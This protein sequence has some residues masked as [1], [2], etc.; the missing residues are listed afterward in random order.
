MAATFCCCNCP[1]GPAAAS[2]TTT[3]TAFLLGENISATLLPVHSTLSL[4]IHPPLPL[5]AAAAASQ[6]NKCDQKKGEEPT[7][8]LWKVRLLKEKKWF[9]SNVFSLLEIVSHYSNKGPSMATSATITFTFKRP[10]IGSHYY[11]LCHFYHVYYE[12][13]SE[14]LW[15]EK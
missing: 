8:H 6:L 15:E 14:I 2:N 12:S 3:T 11:V 10:Q 1:V 5:T 9:F 13:S 7:T 4:F